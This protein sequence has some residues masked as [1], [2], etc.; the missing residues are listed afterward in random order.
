MTF[1]GHI[2]LIIDERY[3]H[4]YGY[5]EYEFVLSGTLVR[6]END[7]WPMGIYIIFVKGYQKPRYICSAYEL[8]TLLNKV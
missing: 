3:R 7:T 4:P 5:M 2:R 8:T 6:K 1:D